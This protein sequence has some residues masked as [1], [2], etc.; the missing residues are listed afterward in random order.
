[1]TA[2]TRSGRSYQLVGAPGNAR[3]GEYAWQNWCSK[4]EVVSEVDVT[5]EYFS[6][7][8]LFTKP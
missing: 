5:D 1:M 4:N 6:I 2:T 3:I 8:K 7:D